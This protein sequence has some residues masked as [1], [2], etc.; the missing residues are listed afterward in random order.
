MDLIWY[1]SW[2]TPQ[3]CPLGMLE[4]SDGKLSRSVLRGEWGCEA[5]DLP[6]NEKDGI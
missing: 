3:W 4:P 1:N 6:G 5:P 2:G